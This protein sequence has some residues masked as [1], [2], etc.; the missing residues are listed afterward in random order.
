MQENNQK[1]AKFALIL[2]THYLAQRKEPTLKFKLTDG[3]TSTTTGIDELLCCF[4]EAV[5][6]KNENVRKDTNS[7][8]DIVTL[9]TEILMKNE[10]EKGLNTRS[11][12]S[13]CISEDIC[14]IFISL[15]RN[16]DWNGT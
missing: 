16:S 14:R 7:A 15:S 1:N 12:N 6:M 10:K 5:D 13:Y 11:W 2:K 4:I 3:A 8:V 9:T